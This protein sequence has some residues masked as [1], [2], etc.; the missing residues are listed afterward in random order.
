[1]KPSEECYQAIKKCVEQLVEFDPLRFRIAI[2]EADETTE[3]EIEAQEFLKVD[4]VRCGRDFKVYGLMSTISGFSG[5]GLADFAEVLMRVKGEFPEA[6]NAIR[7]T[8]ESLDMLFF[9]NMR[10]SWR[11]M[12]SV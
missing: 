9:E 12:W 11:E 3:P 10:Q 7:A 4:G 6:F 5:A 2:N 1:M 8:V